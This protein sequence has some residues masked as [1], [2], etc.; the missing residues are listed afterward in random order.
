M[1]STAQKIKKLAP[2]LGTKDLTPWEQEFLT[3]IVARSR[4]GQVSGYTDKQMESLDGLLTKH[5]GGSDGA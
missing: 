3:S 5:F 1:L 4:S 2:L